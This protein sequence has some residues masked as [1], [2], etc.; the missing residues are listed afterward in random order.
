[1][2]DFSVAKSDGEIPR[3]RGV[4]HFITKNL[5]SS[6]EFVSLFERTGAAKVRSFAMSHSQS[7][8]GNKLI[9]SLPPDDAARLGSIARLV[10]PGRGSVLSS[11]SEPATELWFPHGGLIA[12]TTADAS[13]RS[14]QTGVVG[15]EGCAGLGALFPRSAPLPDAIVQIEAPMLVVHAA[16]LRPMLAERPAVQTAMAY[17]LY[18]LAIQSLQNIACNRLHGLRARCCRWLLTIG[19]RSSS[20][21]LPLTQETF[22]T[23][24]GSGR[25]RVNGVLAAL[26]NQGLVRRR[27]GGIRLIDRP[28]LEA[29]SC[30]CYRLSRP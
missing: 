12:L 19:D 21:D 13:G 1:M 16:Q 22:A 17:F 29:E 28:A 2:I 30:A 27:R 23:L 8:K 7:V 11:R 9:E 10:H 15:S 20:N 4:Y 3:K 24:L 5:N 6:R 14:V 25:P 26:E 18:N